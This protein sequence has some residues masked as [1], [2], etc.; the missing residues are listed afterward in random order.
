M[1]SGWSAIQDSWQIS[2]TT[3]IRTNAGP[4][5]ASCSMRFMSGTKVAIVGAG[6]VGATIAYASL[7][8]GQARTIALYDLNAA[9][10]NAEALD[11]N[12]GLSFVP[13]TSVVGSDDLSVCDN[14]DIIVIT[15][16]AKQQSGESRLALAGRNTDIFRNLIPD[17]ASR[18]PEAVL[19]VVTNPVD[20]LTYVARE[21]SGFP[22]SRV[23]GS[24]TVLDTSRL[25]FLLAQRCGVA[26]PNVHA[27]IA[28]EHGD[29]EFALWSSASIGLVP[30]RQ[31]VD[32]NGAA[33]TQAALNAIE[34]QVKHAAY[35]IIRGKGATTYAV[36]LAV[37]SI[38]GSILGDEHRILPVSTM[39]AGTH[40]ISDVTLS[41][42]VVL[43]ARGVQR[44]ITVPISSDEQE[45]LEA[46]AAT[47]RDSIRS[48]GF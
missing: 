31:W 6:G 3:S 33:Q 11:L 45:R 27:T 35:E 2:P 13:S 30:I 25:R 37:S 29:S 38:I 42:P 48:V 21:L 10:V 47:I 17:L 7:I 20:V 26:V 16:G 8:Q 19:L 24:G 4:Q 36:G 23:I 14:A 39:Q 44:D 15:A 32:A 46:S 9:K 18:S 41:M 22:P 12:H 40:S 43:G 28:G 1:L 5:V 34:D